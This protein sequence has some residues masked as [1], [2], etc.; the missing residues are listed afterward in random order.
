MRPL[1]GRREANCPPALAWLTDWLEIGPVRT[2]GLRNVLVVGD[3]AGAGLLATRLPDADV[4]TA[5][6]DTPVGGEFDLVAV[7]GAT[8][9][10]AE[11]LAAAA[12]VAT[13][14]TLLVLAPGDASAV[15]DFS[16][17]GWDP[18]AA[19]LQLVAF[20]DLTDGASRSPGPP[21]RWLRATY[22]RGTR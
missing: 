9:R 4:V 16:P 18:A 22:R 19:D 7:V 17:S 1:P 14:G 12:A 11:V 6:R 20:D 10:P 13:G 21:H 2:D 15:T 8:P 3:S 5:G